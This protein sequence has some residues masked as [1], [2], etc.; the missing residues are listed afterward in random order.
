MPQLHITDIEARTIRRAL[1]QLAW[2]AAEPPG[3]VR[4]IQRRIEESVSLIRNLLE[5]AEE[6]G[7][8][9]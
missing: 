5:A 1:D 9:H 7:A 6:R 8:I 4:V 2:T 3:D